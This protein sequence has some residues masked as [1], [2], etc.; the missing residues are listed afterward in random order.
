M[1]VKIYSYH[2]KSDKEEEYLKIQEEADRVYSR[3][4]DK[5]TLHLQS[6]SDKT[7]WLELHIYENETI[8][9]DNIQIIDQQPEIQVLYK[10]FREI[11]T[12]LEEIS[13]ENYHLFDFK[14][15]STTVNRT[16]D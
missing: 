1:F 16:G 4:L 11:I 5:K 2:I 6:M 14:G 12:S 8:Y 3:F 10:R 7:N 15:D 9:N 13:E